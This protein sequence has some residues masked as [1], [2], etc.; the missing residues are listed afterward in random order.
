MD[1]DC[2][3]CNIISG[4]IPAEKVYEDEH[5]LAF[6]D[7]Q[8]VSAGHTL[9]IP[10]THEQNLL[11][12]SDE[13]LCVLIKTVRTVANAVK[14][15]TNAGGVNVHFNNEPPAGQEVFHTHAHII[16]RFEGDGLKMWGKV[17]YKDEEMEAMSKKIRA[18]LKS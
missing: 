17:E 10:K 7:I 5:T 1:Q 3:F 14:T 11:T 18:Q 16:P 4:D 12:G 8:P 15:A 13:A 6:L 9:V 2:I